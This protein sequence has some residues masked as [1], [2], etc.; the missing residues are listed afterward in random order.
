MTDLLS[1]R[2]SWKNSQQDGEGWGVENETK[3]YFF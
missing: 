1:F 3:Y 2:E